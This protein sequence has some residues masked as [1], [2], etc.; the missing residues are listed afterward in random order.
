LEDYKLEKVS[1]VVLKHREVGY[2]GKEHL[3]DYKQEMVFLEE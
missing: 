1:L 3:E 2:E